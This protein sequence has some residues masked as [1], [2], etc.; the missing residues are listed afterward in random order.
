VA[1]DNPVSSAWTQAAL[2]WTP[3]EPGLLV[4]IDRTAYFGG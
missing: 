2:G 4:D 3:T 1:A